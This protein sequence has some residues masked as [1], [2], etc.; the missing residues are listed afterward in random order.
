MY[1]I[2]ILANIPLINAEPLEGYVKVS[3]AAVGLLSKVLMRVA[4]EELFI[5]GVKE[6]SKSGG[7]VLN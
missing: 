6:S 1:S 5:S 7:K 3:K 2:L 4:E